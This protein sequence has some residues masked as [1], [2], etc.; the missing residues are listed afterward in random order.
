MPRANYIETREIA[1]GAISG[2]WAKI[3]SPFER[4]SVLLFGANDT[5]GA[6]YIGWS[7]DPSDPDTEP[8][9]NG[10]VILAGS[11]MVL[12]IGAQV[13]NKQSEYTIPKNTQ[14]WCKQISAPVAG[15][16]Y[17]TPFV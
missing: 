11:S 14:L 8:T 13:N 7:D 2:S 3:G 6:M 15:S 5:S 10:P 9:K 16:V 4:E 17:I 1:A 12:D